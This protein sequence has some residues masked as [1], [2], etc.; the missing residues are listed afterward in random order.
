MKI[1]I[2]H[3]EKAYLNGTASSPIDKKH[4]PPLTENGKKSCI[5]KAK[6]LVETYGVPKM[7]ISSPFRR[8]RETAENLKIGIGSSGKDIKI[9]IDTRISEYL[10]NHRNSNLDITE[11]TAVYGIRHPESWKQFT[12]RIKEYVEEIKKNVESKDSK[13]S[14]P[15][16]TEDNNIIWVVTHGVVIQS[17]CKYLTPETWKKRNFEYLDTEIYNHKKI[18]SDQS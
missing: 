14:K 4:D 17:I 2:R 5:E 13:D 6:T 18:T 9:V 3:A 10:G 16:E 15:E 12:V 11:E 1:F 8:C 7:I